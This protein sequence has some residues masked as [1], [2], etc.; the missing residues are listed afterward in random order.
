MIFKRLHLFNFRAQNAFLQ[1]IGNAV[2]SS[3]LKIT[4]K[5]AAK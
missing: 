1:E 4:V 5:V 3:L 2:F